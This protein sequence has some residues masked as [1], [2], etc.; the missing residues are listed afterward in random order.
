MD[1][2]VWGVTELG[3]HLADNM[4]HD[5]KK[6][7]PFAYIDN[8][9]FL[10]NTLIEGISV[11]SI[12]ELL[13]KKD[14]KNLTVLLAIR[15]ARN[16]FQVFEQ[17]KQIPVENVGIVKPRV[18]FSKLQIDPWSRDEIVWS[19]FKGKRHR[20]VPRI[21]INLTDAC[22][23]KCKGCSHF[24]SLY[25]EDSI[26]PI[27]EYK[28][29]LLCLREIGEILKL[30][31]LGGEPFLLK[32]LDEYIVITRG[33]FPETDI[34][35]VT[36]G[37]LI[38]KVQEKIL[39]AIKENDVNVTISPYQPTLKSEKKITANLNRFGIT[40]HLEKEEVIEFA[41]G[42]TLQDIHNPK[43]SSQNCLS[44]ACTF[45]RNGKLY[46]CPMEG[47]I[48]DFYDYY[49]IKKKYEG[50][51]YIYQ[52]KEVVYE[53]LVEYAFKPIEM[54]KYCAEEPE[55]IPWSVKSNPILED[56]LYGK[57]ENDFI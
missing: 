38:P 52:D 29:D 53:R 31:L 33:I 55:Y 20:I 34:E 26:Y 25:K 18:L 37:L 7:R 54:C 8:N 2:V 22:N 28:K 49:G 15:N 57:I 30:R 23:L 36:N 21:E 14:C 1:V 24:S 44:A 13:K 35:I 6:V 19:V 47:L 45:L 9:V 51:I 48:N 46:K 3:K 56:W 5:N 11:I 4:V 17:L 43:I 10:Q 40:W 41:R 27:S 16:I 42:L 32:N 50:G 12:E 39:F